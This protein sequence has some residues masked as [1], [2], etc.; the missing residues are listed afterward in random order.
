MA[1]T[2]GVLKESADKR[3][4]ITPDNIKRSRIKDVSWWIE[5]GAGIEAGF[6]DQ[7]YA[8]LATIKDKGE[9]LTG[10]DVLVTIFS[11][12]DEDLAKI[13][14]GTLLISQFRSYQDPGIIDKLSKYPIRV[15]SMDM[16]PR[17]TLAQSM[18][19]LS[20]MA[21]IAGYRAVLMAAQKLPRYFPMMITSAG[22][23]RPAKALIIGAGV[24]GL[25]AIATARKLGAVVEAFDVRQAAKEEVQSLGAKFV[26]VAGAAE[27]KGA[28]GYAV[29]Q[30]EEF[31][32]RQRAEVQARA[33]KADVIICTAQV[34]GRKAPVL[35]EADTIP[36]MRHG[37]VIIDLA[38]STGGNC[39]LTEND[40][41]IVKHGVTI[42]GNSSLETEM[43]ED[44]SQMYGN[45]VLNLLNH[46]TKEGVLNLK[47]DDEI[48]KGSLIKS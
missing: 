14:E 41:T 30:S 36:L 13:K 24:A 18:D 35:I 28:G 43:P 3:V 1:M 34:R 2:I 46:I 17:T 6:E 45:N 10:A 8:G 38:A 44:A 12:T 21:S 25:Q 5:S 22:S 4:A 26:E 23:I 40:K 19:V 29:Q 15:I 31:L 16:I 11:P 47:M 33:A 32:T 27:D 20:S 39:A 9:I 37:S 7:H 42:V 48:V